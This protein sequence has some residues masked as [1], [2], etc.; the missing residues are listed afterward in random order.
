MLPGDVVRPVNIKT[1]LLAGGRGIVLLCAFAAAGTCAAQ[2]VDFSGAWMPL[3]HEDAP[4]RLPGPEL[5]DYTGLPL[6]DAGRLRGDSYDADRI[7]VVTE[8]QCRQ[9][10]ADYSMRGLATLRIDREL[11][12][13]T[14]RLLA[15]HTRIGFQS[16]ERT[17]WLD[18]RPHPPPE[19]AHSW[20]GFS[21]GVWNGNVLTITTTHLKSYYLRRNG[22]PATPNR[23]LT[24]HWMRH[25][26]FLTV[27]TIIDDPAMLTEP[28]VRSQSWVL[29]PGQQM[30]PTQCEYVT[31]IPD[32][33]EP[34]PQH[35]PGTNPWLHDFAA[36]Y[37]LPYAATRGGAETLYPEYRAVMGLPEKPPPAQCEV[38]CIC[39]TLFDCQRTPGTNLLGGRLPGVPI[40]GP[41]RAGAPAEGAPR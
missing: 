14:Q 23:T 20:Q 29:D 31:E 28:L 3:Y 15:F 2:N 1:T 8:Y 12:P 41:A 38:Y 36:T 24:E 27:V 34:V 22:V 4:E 26:E 25:G 37:G 16:M 39:S 13:P 40:G 9:H 33:A 17:I 7:S 6:S 5:G 11:D 10:S 19:A 30:G 32:A 35:L 21:T 18:G